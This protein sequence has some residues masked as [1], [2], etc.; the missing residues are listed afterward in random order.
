MDFFHLL[1]YSLVG[2]I[3]VCLASGLSRRAGRWGGVLAAAPVTP[4]FAVL[5]FTDAGLAPDLMVGLSSIAATLVVLGI[6]AGANG[7][8][9]SRFVGRLPLGLLLVVLVPPL[10]WSIALLSHVLVLLV[11]ALGVVVAEVRVRSAGSRAPSS[12]GRIRRS[13]GLLRFFMGAFA[14]FL[15][16]VV[17]EWSPAMASL[18]ALFP[19]VFTVGLFL[20]E[21]D[22]GRPQAVRVVSGGVPGSVGVASFVVLVS[23]LSASGVRSVP[24]LLLAGWGAYAVASACWVLVSDLLMRLRARGRPPAAALQV[25][26]EPSRKRS[27]RAPSHP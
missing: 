27:W 20:A 4:T 6:A 17:M 13:G 21:F 10:A 14:V 23:V 15:V 3:A 25:P 1:V 18:A 19:L 22:G 5:L 9:S 26:D 16:A 24:W 8:V 12:P 7:R 2:G 11:V